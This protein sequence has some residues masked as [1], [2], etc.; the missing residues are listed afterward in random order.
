MVE[1]RRLN[2]LAK[3]LDSVLDLPEGD[4]V[5]ALS[6][7]AD[8]AGLALL[9][10]N[11]GRRA[12]AIH[13][14]HGT[15]AAP[16]LRKSAA[17]I[18]GHLGLDLHIEAVALP[19]GAFSE[20]RARFERYRA[21]ETQR[22][23]GEWVITGHT[24]ED[25]AETILMNLIRGA[26][27]LGM[28]GIPRLSNGW[29]SRPILDADRGD[30]RELATLAGLSYLDDPSNLDLEFTR[31]AI[32]RTVLPDLAR[33]NPSVVDSLARTASL[34]REHLDFIEME[35]ESLPIAVSRE[36]AE[37]PI[38]HL[39]TAPRAIAV[40]A[41]RRVVRLLRPPYPPTVGET[42]RIWEVVTG[43]RRATEIEGDIRVEKRGSMLS[44]EIGSGDAHTWSPISL[45]PGIHQMASTVLEVVSHDGACRV[46]PIGTW[47]AVFPQ[48][49][50][51][52][53]EVDS[54]NRAVVTV[55]GVLA[56]NPGV[57]RHPVAFY[58]AGSTGYLSVSAR[59]ESKWTSSL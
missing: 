9:V 51:L 45:T 8:S 47:S 44:L 2:E 26:G 36:T 58:E 12:R 59:E 49:A 23:E 53:A 15:P 18:A 39:V 43:G 4:L 14:D 29:V 20:D 33:F 50:G 19:D 32:R 54:N 11:I 3:M 37:I 41:I 57:R 46:A 52:G 16:Q 35:V 5:V 38:G 42:E 7:G 55:N 34:L 17:A 40:E 27:P 30:V 28:S 1:T 48:D 6:G 10:V 13:V 21:L 22:S 25:Q 56:W 31:N 24:R